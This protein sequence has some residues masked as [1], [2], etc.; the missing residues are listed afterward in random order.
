MDHSP[1]HTLKP[2]AEFESPKEEA[3]NQRQPHTSE[4]SKKRRTDA[5]KK[6]Y[7][8]IPEDGTGQIVQDP[9]PVHET[10]SAEDGTLSGTKSDQE[11]TSS[12]KQKYLDL[13]P[14]K[15]ILYN[16]R[17]NEVLKNRR[18][19]NNEILLQAAS[20]ADPA[21]MEEA[22]KIKAQKRKRCDYQNSVR[23]NLTEEQKKEIN[24]K[25]AAQRQMRKLKKAKESKEK[26]TDVD[27]N[28][29]DHAGREE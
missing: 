16:Q 23:A 21:V 22:E 27:D 24:K 13:N 7:R 9:E 4:S 3:S 29:V 10:Q 2:I 11:S 28:D 1:Q 25:V 8:Q 20:G 18:R 12:Q 17:R 15:R 26:E 5:A 6:R 14:E 19:K